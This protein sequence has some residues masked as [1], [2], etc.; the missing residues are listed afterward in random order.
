MMKILDFFQQ[1]L[2]FFY[3][4]IQKFRLP[5][6]Y[7]ATCNSPG[8]DIKRPVKYLFSMKFISGWQGL[9]E[10]GKKE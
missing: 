1:F 2:Y 6:C 8:Y 10:K 5:L 3:A 9:F 4:T 7:T